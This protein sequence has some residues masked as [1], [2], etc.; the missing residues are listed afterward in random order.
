MTSRL[1]RALLRLPK[2]AEQHDPRKLVETFVDVGALFTMLSSVD[3]QVIYGRRGTGK[4]HAMSFLADEVHRAGDLAIS[5][6][7]RTI[8]STGG[9]YSDTSLP[10][11]E[12]G[13]R[14]LLDTLVALHDGL[15]DYTLGLEDEATDT[16]ETLAHLDRLA[17]EIADSVKIVGDVSVTSVEQIQSVRESSSKASVSLASAPTLAVEAGATTEDQE[18]RGESVSRAGPERHRV[19]FGAVGTLLRRIIDSLP[20]ARLWILVD[21]WSSTPLDLQ[22]LLADL[23]RRSL[24]PIA[25]ATVKIAAIEQRSEFRI[26]LPNGDHLG[27]ELGA[28]TAADLD[29]DDFMVFGNNAEKAMDFFARLLHKHVAAAFS[30]EGKGEEGPSSH[31][32]LIQRAF[33]QTNAFE[34]YVRAAEGV[35]R[36][37]IN[38]IAIA[39]HRADDSQISISHVRSAARD[40]YQRDK[41]S[42]VS[43]N[44]DAY[45]L[46][47]WIIAEVLGNRQAKAFML[48][49]GDDRRH[50]LIRELYDARV[51]HLIRRG[52]AARD[53]P[54]VRFNGWGLDYGCYVDLIT[55][56]KAPKGLFTVELE[57][58]AQDEVFIQVPTDDYRSIRKA[59]LDLNEFDRRP[60][61]QLALGES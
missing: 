60:P 22:A 55:T 49:Q 42:A 16:T 54:G 17:D 37:A 38:I 51:L 3:H 48:K 58:E 4:T 24:F 10:I 6:D 5:V 14:L 35:P 44:P 21:E 8:G 25:N 27:I 9:I 56:V 43:A 11:T 45:D 39:A 59:I 41:E 53:R 18:R 20:I 12:R 47:H 28:D 23:I 2:R 57:G 29:L 30:V 46:L 15:V 50:P 19:H 61:R 13:T 26:S 7:M 1:N 36:D 32:Q 34:E 31:R 40:W 52:I 33:T